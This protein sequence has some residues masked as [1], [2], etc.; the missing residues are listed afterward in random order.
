MSSKIIFIM[1]VC[2]MLGVGLFFIVYGVK[3][4]FIDKKILV[5]SWKN[6]YVFGRDAMF[7][8]CFYIFIGIMSLFVLVAAIIRTLSQH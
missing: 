2:I 8:G 3:G 6:Q 4:G 1:F 5:N 7:R